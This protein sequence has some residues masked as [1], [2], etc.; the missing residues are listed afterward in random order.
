MATVAGIT[1]AIVDSP[2]GPEI[3]IYSGFGGTTITV[4]E[5]ERFA[6]ELQM[7]NRTARSKMSASQRY[8]HLP[9][10]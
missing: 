9:M 5:S 7:L 3:I 1:V 2:H 4:F 6:H 8:K 10:R